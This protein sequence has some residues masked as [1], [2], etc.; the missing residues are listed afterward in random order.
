MLLRYKGSLLVNEEES[1]GELLRE[2]GLKKTPIRISMLE[3]FYRHDFALGAADILELMPKGQDKV[4]IYRALASFEEKGILHQASKDA[5]GVKYA[6]ASKTGQEEKN[7]HA[8]FVCNECQRTY[9]LEEVK[10]PEVEV[11]GNF[12]IDQINYTIRGI[13]EHCRA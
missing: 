10:V 4:T 13:C 6:M 8:H 7:V 2:Y 5:Q 1:I 11:K 3:M 9:C 12:S